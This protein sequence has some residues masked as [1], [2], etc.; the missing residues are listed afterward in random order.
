MMHDEDFD[1]ED[2][3]DEADAPSVGEKGEEPSSTKVPASEP[4][5]AA[6][7]VAD[8]AVFQDEDLANLEINDEDEEED[9]GD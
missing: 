9:D 4:A 8:K 1:D 5:T 6:G 7:T 2:G 3:E